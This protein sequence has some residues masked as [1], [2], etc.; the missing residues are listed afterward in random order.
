MEPS[1]TA[2]G[3]QG[4]GAYFANAG[5]DVHAVVSL[6][7]IVAGYVGCIVIRSDGSRDLARGARS[8][9]GA[10]TGLVPG[11]GRL[12]AAPVGVWYRPVRVAERYSWMPWLPVLVRSG[13]ERTGSAGPADARLHAKATAG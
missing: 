4:T 12:D 1:S 7:P 8:A 2:P 13:S 9:G 3:P 10:E 11:D 5:E 6:A